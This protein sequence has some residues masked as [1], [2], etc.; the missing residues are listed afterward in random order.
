[1]WLSVFA[2]CIILQVVSA[3]VRLPFSVFFLPLIVF[4]S[5]QLSFV[6]WENQHYM[7]KVVSDLQQVDEFLRVL[8][9]PPPIKQDS[10]DITEILLK[11]AL[12]TITPPI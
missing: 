7:I 12:N 2:L 8:R 4:A 11:V 10:H 1:V 5:F 9:F 3:E 6:P